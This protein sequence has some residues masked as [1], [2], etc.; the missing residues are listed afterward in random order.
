LNNRID[1][2]RGESI[3]LSGRDFNSLLNVKPGVQHRPGGG[4]RA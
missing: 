3:P 2:Q 4:S 1:S